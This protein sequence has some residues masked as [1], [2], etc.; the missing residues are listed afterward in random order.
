MGG[1]HRR[2]GEVN[3]TRMFYVNLL[4]LPPLG[5]L[6]TGVILAS[7]NGGP[8]WASVICGYAFGS[9]L[10]PYVLELR[11]AKKDDA[12]FNESWHRMARGLDQ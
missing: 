10:V 3:R 7:V 4:W 9:F 11:R 5:F 1:A 12:E 2:G 8:Y 6:L